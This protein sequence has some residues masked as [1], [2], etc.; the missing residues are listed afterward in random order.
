MTEFETATRTNHAD[1][2]GSRISWG[3][4]LAGCMTAL[5]MY[6]LLTTLGAAVGLSISDR[7]N[8]STLHTGAIAW[9]FLT[10]A[11]ALF[12]GG[13]VTSL[14]TI[15]ED[16]IEAMLHGVIM[17]AVLFTMLLVLGAAGIHSGFNAMAMIASQD[18]AAQ[19]WERA[20]QNDGVTPAQIQEWR[21][22]T[23]A[24][25]RGTA[26]ESEDREAV[27]AAATRMTWYAFAGTWLS[28]IAGALGGLVGAGP[29][30]RVVSVRTTTPHRVAVSH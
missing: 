27:K 20:A 26:T 16:H 30:F 17:W 11:A 25:S 3:A 28:M 5:G 23:G 2:L 24:A 21:R 1:S 12:V 8:P 22:Q 14:F 19:N 9:A 18:G 4:I 13:V 6:F 15:G 10:T 7:T 29:T